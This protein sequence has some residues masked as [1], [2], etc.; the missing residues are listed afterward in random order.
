MKPKPPEAP[1]QSPLGLLM[2]RIGPFFCFLRC[3]VTPCVCERPNGFIHARAAQ[4]PKQLLRH[5]FFCGKVVSIGFISCLFTHPSSSSTSL[6][7]PLCSTVPVSPVHHPALPRRSCSPR[8]PP[9]PPQRSAAFRW[10]KA[11][12]SSESSMCF[13]FGPPLH[14]MRLA[15]CLFATLH[16]FAAPLA[17]SAAGQSV[18][19]TA[20]HHVPFRCAI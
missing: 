20:L 13:N 12:T 11:A 8:A 6:S 4:S 9:T 2:L 14:A 1:Y 17:V 10:F 5:E 3:F 18:R 7:A 19:C 15:L 16:L